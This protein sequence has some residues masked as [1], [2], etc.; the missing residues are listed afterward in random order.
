MHHKGP[1]HKEYLTIV[2][3]L[4]DSVLDRNLLISALDNLFKGKN[5]F[6]KQ[7]FDNLERVVGTIYDSYLPKSEE[8]K[9]EDFNFIDFDRMR[10]LT[11]QIY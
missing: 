4:A 11:K 9:E 5:F 8:H 7:P 1:L 6:A 2:E 3:M 10:N